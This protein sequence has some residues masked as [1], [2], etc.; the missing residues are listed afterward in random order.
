M[1]HNAYGSPKKCLIKINNFKL[2]QFKDKN[3]TVI[4]GMRFETNL[5]N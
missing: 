5:S 2:P 1:P 3:H 4:W